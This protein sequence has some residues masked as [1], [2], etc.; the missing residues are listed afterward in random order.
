MSTW[1]KVAYFDKAKQLKGGLVA[2]S[3]AGLPFLLHEGLEVAFVPPQTDAP[4]TGRVVS[5]SEASVSSAVVSFDSV[6][7]VATAELL[8]GCYCLV[9]SADIAS[10]DLYMSG[11]GLSGWSAYDQAQGFVGTV[12]R[13]DEMP[14]QTMLVLDRS[15]AGTAGECLVPLVDEFVLSFDE[16]NQAIQLALPSG[17]L[18]L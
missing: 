6:G 9:R 14:G 7:D 15:A 10:E 12:A 17:L 18:T 3:V 4:R 2:R 8:V 1:L 16:E 11:V 5:V 13:I